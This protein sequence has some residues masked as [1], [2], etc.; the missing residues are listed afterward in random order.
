[1]YEG[2]EDH[3][4]R[5]GYALVFFYF[6]A[7]GSTN[8]DVFQPKTFPIPRGIIPQNFS[9][10]GFAVSE[11]LG[12]K[13]TNT[14]THSLTDWRFYRVILITY[15]YLTVKIN[16][17]FKKVIFF[18]F[19]WKKSYFVIE[20]TEPR[21]LIITKPRNTPNHLQL[22]H[23][24]MCYISK[25]SKPSIKIKVVLSRL[26]ASPLAA[27]AASMDQKLQYLENITD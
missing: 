22:I 9:S 6:P 26:V 16:H 24:N 27:T 15:L 19:I 8:P 23:P 14:Q 25:Y 5:T 11:E 7:N 1:M 12:N 3:R 13:Q 17:L 20:I 2:Y 18:H 21:N 10:L 4:G